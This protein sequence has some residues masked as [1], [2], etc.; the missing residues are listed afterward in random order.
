MRAAE[1]M[2]RNAAHNRRRG[3]R[4]GLGVLLVLATHSAAEADGAPHIPLVPGLVGVY[5]AYLPEQSD[6]ETMVSVR[7]ADDQAVTLEIR[8]VDPSN[9]G[10]EARGVA[11][12]KV[13][14]R[15]DLQRANRVVVTFHTEDPEIFPGSTIG[16]ISSDLLAQLKSGMEPPFILGIGEGPFG[17]LGAR[18][19]YRGHLRRVEDDAAA[20]PVLLNGKRTTLPAI[21]TWGTLSVGRDSAAVEL[22]WLNQPDNAMLLRGIFKGRSSQLVRIDLP[23]SPKADLDAASGLASATCRAELHGIYFDTGSA[24]LLPQSIATITEIAEVLSAKPDWQITI[25]G[26][27]DNT[28]TE[29]D[30]QRLSKQRAESVLKA[31][32][33]QQELPASR[34][35]A[36][37][38][39]ESRPVDTNDTVEGR[40]HNRRVELARQCP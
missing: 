14:R 33:D 4:T 31:L 16:G 30:N 39:G 24:V 29:M 2:M 10:G 9:N 32:I 34:F 6:K 23:D 13:V 35:K 22:W 20:I 21:H 3:V 40:A 5:A 12:T 18:K 11:V 1:E 26:H 17:S 28:G 8:T 25:E 7:S 19:Y 37:G 38:F 27:T 36:V 15:V